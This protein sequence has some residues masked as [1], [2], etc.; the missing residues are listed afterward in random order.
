MA[1]SDK[2]LSDL[3]AEGTAP[4]SDPGFT[5][6]VDAE[7]RR[8]R[9]GRRLVA[10]ALPATGVLMLSS[11]LYGAASVIRPVLAPLFDAAPQFM[12]VPLPVALS[13]LAAGLAVSARRFVL[14]R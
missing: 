4:E 10:L 5:K 13:A 2:L 8:A 9:L 11:A 1:M 3:F 14:F 12:G 7:I 6:R